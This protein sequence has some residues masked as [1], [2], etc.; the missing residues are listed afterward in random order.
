[1]DE[2]RIVTTSLKSGAIQ[3]LFKDTGRIRW[4]YLAKDYRLMRQL[5]LDLGDKFVAVG[6]DDLLNQVSDE[7]RTDHVEWIDGLNRANSHNLEWWFGVVSSRNVY[8]SNLFLYSCYLLT[9]ERIWQ[10]QDTR[11]NLIIVE[12]P[13]MAECVLQWFHE[14]NVKVTLQHESIL[15]RLLRKFRYFLRNIYSVAVLCDRFLA[16]LMTRINSSVNPQEGPCVVVDTFVHEYSLS[17]NGVFKDRYYPFLHEFL[18][19]EGHKVLVHSV[20]HGFRYNYISI[21]RRM[22]KSLTSFIIQEDYLRFSDYAAAL[23]ASY[24]LH[25][26][27]AVQNRFRGINLAPLVLEE[28]RSQSSLPVM[29]AVLTH[30]LWQ[31]LREAGVE[32]TWII[33]WY[34]NQVL[35][36]AL[37]AGVRGA[38]PGIGILGAQMFIHIPNYLSLYP[39]QSELDAGLV[40]DILLQMGK[41]QCVNVQKYARGISCKS[42]AALRY[43]HLFSETYNTRKIEFGNA[44]LVVLPYNMDESLEMLHS[45]RDVLLD[46]ADVVTFTI[47]CHP[48]YSSPEDIIAAF[49]PEQW[50]KQFIIWN[51][52]ISDAFALA[53]M[54]VVSN[55]SSMVEAVVLGIPTIFIRRHSNL[56]MNPLADVPVAG[57]I[58][59]CG[60]EQIKRAIVHFRNLPAEERKVLRRSGLLL[61]DQYFTTVDDNNMKAFVFPERVT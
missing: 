44:I 23:K 7:I 36:K 30:R 2:I 41:A 37:I 58:S 19:K 56:N 39:S 42:A 54:V 16:A 15:I 12:S 46:E 35:D 17:K 43:A 59:C 20:L 51:G 3:G 31:R 9:L 57:F 34:E 47:K 6:I 13:G 26:T 24:S 32:L 52:D 11:P 60:F 10:H 33:N 48:D 22:R 14:Q 5:S 4:V 29:N 50:P 45:L 28:H 1:M 49:G 55:S 38:Y 18:A 53:A 61:C 21:F 8:I 25:K 27:I 40:P